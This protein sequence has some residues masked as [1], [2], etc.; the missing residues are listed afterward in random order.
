M[1]SAFA[2][3]FY[4]ACAALGLLLVIEW[5]PA[6]D[7]AVTAP[8][9]AAHAAHEGDSHE[10]AARDTTL[11]AETVIRRPLF[12]IGRRPAR[13]ATP[14]HMVSATGLPRL[15]G[16]MITAGGRRAIFMPDG[17]KPLTLAEGATLDDNTVRLIAP[18]RVVL[19][20]PKGETILRPTY[21]SNR[22]VPPPPMLPPSFNYQP[23]PPAFMPPGFTPPGVQP[24]ANG[25]NQE[26]NADGAQG[27][28]PPAMPYQPPFPG[29]RGPFI[30]RGRN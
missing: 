28:P 6:G 12:T 11:W 27:V 25:Q 14:S 7:P 16:I 8:P 15:S 21:D 3:W 2:S 26:E 10:I 19:S 20:G 18:D 5:L 13:T 9:L 4:G 1:I 24:A 30:P 23:Q 29:I 22:V 17:G